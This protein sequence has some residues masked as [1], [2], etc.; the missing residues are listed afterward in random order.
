MLTHDPVDVE[1]RQHEQ[2]VV[3]TG[4]ARTRRRSCGHRIEVGVVEHHALRPA[5]RTAGVDQ[6][7]ERVVAVLRRF[8][9]RGGLPGSQVVASRRP[10]PRASGSEA[11]RR[12][13]PCVGVRDL[14]VR[15]G[16]QAGLIGVTAAPS[17]HAATIAT[18]SSTR[19]GSMIATTSPADTPFAQYRAGSQHGPRENWCCSGRCRRPP[20]RERRALRGAEIGQCRKVHVGSWLGF[21]E[22]DGVT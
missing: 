16:G 2:A 5:G 6:Q 3:V 9:D 19:F 20:R 14:V 1:Q 10:R 11:R 13:R 21:S 15:L 7:G 17:R 4:D 18:R 12:R 22:V 8:D